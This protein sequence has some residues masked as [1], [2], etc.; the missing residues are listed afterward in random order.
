MVS[1]AFLSIALVLFTM[2][3]EQRNPAQVSARRGH[4]P[5][6]GTELPP[7]APTVD[8]ES[9]SLPPVTAEGV[10]TLPSERPG[11]LRLDLARG[12]AS[13]VVRVQANDPRFPPGIEKLTD[14]DTTTLSRSEDVNP[15]V[16]TFAF[17][18]KI[19]LKTIRIYLSYSSYDWKLYLDSGSPLV[20]REAADEAW[21][22]IDLPV[23]EVVQQLRLEIRRLQRDNFVH[24]N[25][26]EFYTENGRG[27]KSRKVV[28]GE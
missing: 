1:R 8:V 25:E 11:T 20:V 2:A 15:L 16:L 4:Q 12:L 24:V 14:S 7:A 23:V 21:S 27:P 26:I 18:T 13:G 22:E 28:E 17:G 5:I 6:S 19:P 9:I 3:C 10:P